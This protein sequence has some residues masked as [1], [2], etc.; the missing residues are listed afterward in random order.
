MHNFFYLL[1]MIQIVF[2]LR[3]KAMAGY[4]RIFRK[5]NAISLLKTKVNQGEFSSI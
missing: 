4:N 2:L 5:E 1:E 3:A